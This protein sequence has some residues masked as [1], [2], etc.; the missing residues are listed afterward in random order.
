[1]P[2]KIFAVTNVKVGP[3][4]DGW[5]A[6]GSPIDRSKF[7]DAQLLEL[8]DAGAI[9]IRTVD[10]PTAPSG[11]ALDEVTKVDTEVKE[12]EKTESETEVKPETNTDV[13]TEDDSEPESETETETEE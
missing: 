7:T 13:A 5:F 1:M 11:D 10:E 3:D 6:S 12:A 8:H 2:K 9:E 4:A